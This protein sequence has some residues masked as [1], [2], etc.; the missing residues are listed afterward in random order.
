MAG[1]LL[2]DL[3]KGTELKTDEARTKAAKG[4]THSAALLHK[5]VS[6]MPLGDD[7]KASTEHCMLFMRTDKKSPDRRKTLAL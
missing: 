1:A 7:S 6:E 4:L 2:I 3:A 5:H